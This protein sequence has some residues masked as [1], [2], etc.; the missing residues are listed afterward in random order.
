[1]LQEELDLL[2]IVVMLRRRWWLIAIIVV[3]GCMAAFGIG[4]ARTPIYEASTKLIMT[5]K[6][7]DPDKDNSI[8]PKVI[9]ANLLMLQTYKDIVRTPN[10]TKKVAANHPE[11]GLSAGAIAGKLTVSTSTTS[12]ILT[13][14]ARDESYSKAA[15][16]VNAA[17]EALIAE[18]VRLYGSGDLEVLYPAEDH[19]GTWPQPV[20]MGLTTLLVVAFALSG[21]V[22]VGLCFV[23]QYFDKW[24]RTERDV[25][26]TLG[27][28]TLVEVPLFI[29]SGKRKSGHRHTSHVKLR[30]AKESR[31]VPIEK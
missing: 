28:E 18:T 11:L 22:G 30:G 8:D 9:Q 7:N 21:M 6:Y 20:N 16:M 4:R 5:N 27:F 14:S 12:Q 17:S 10:V 29:E 23:L 25:A 26:R 19:T 3:V 15:L 2:D 1:M 13:I 24:I 31:N